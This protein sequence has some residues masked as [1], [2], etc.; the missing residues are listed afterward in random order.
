MHAHQHGDHARPPV[1]DLVRNRVN[2]KIVVLYQTL[3]A[4]NSRIA[5]NYMFQN[6]ELQLAGQLLPS[7]SILQGMGKEFDPKEAC[8]K[9][10]CQIQT[11]LSRNAYNMARCANVIDNLKIC[12]HSHGQESI[13]CQNIGAPKQPH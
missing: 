1:V 10:A 3:N 5:A 12:C 6:Q 9:E 2:Y 11:C 13:H 8:K 4:L 7:P